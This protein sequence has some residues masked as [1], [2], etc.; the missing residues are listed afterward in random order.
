MH[1]CK[2]VASLVLSALI[3]FST[4]TISVSA[5]TAKISTVSISAN[6]FA[7][8]S[9]KTLSK[10][11]NTESF[12]DFLGKE[13]LKNKQS[14]DVS[15]Y[16]ITYSKSIGQEIMAL[17]EDEIYEVF[18]V[19]SLNYSILNGK[20]QFIN[21]NYIYSK[22]EF[23]NKYQQL[24]AKANE[25]VAD[26]KNNKQLDD[27]QKALIL[28]DRIAL[29]CEYDNRNYLL[30]TI[31][32]DS[33][34]I[35]GVLLN[36][37]AVCQGYAETYSYLLDMVGIK[38]YICTSQ[39]L[40]HAWNIV[41]IDGKKYHVDVTWDD[42][43]S[44]MNKNEILSSDNAVW[45]IKG[46]VKHT[47]F[48]LSTEALQKGVK[49]SSGHNAEDFDDS[50][51]DTRFDNFFWQN[52]NTGFYLLNGEIYYLENNK[53]GNIKR[54]SDNKTLHT[55]E[56]IWYC[57]G[58]Y[59]YPGNYSKLTCDGERLYY[60][61]SKD[62]YSFD[63]ANTTSRL[64]FSPENANDTNAIYGF[65]YENGKFTYDIGNTPITVNME[66]K[67]KTIDKESP[68]LKVTSTNNL[69]NSQ[70]V[71]AKFNDVSAIYGYWWGKNSDYKKNKFVTSSA[72]SVNLK[73]SDS[74]NYYITVT[75]SFGNVSKTEKLTFY[76][77]NF[78]ANGGTLNNK[79]I[80][81]LA[82]KSIKLPSPT[83]II[84][85]FSGW[86][87]SK[88]AKTG[89]YTITP[90]SNTTYYALWKIPTGKML[91]KNGKDLYY[92]NKG[93]IDKSNT[94][95]LHTDG[96]QYHVKNGKWVK[97]NGLVKIGSTYYYLKNGIVNNSNTLVKY[98]GKQYH[99]KNGKWVKDN[100]LVKIGSTYY[101]LK[102]GIVNNSNTLVKYSGKLYHV[103]NGKWVKDTAIIK[104]NGKQ[105]YVKGGIVQTISKTVKV[106]GKNYKLKKGIVTK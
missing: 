38:S 97:D 58:G 55:I 88:N 77:T 91:V 78:N 46:R 76:K 104:Y 7:S 51:T 103:K 56:D 9:N 89:V 37:T 98:S 72:K 42:P 49:D 52:S 21:P 61:T 99:V 12:R 67:S 100:G 11:V 40:Y 13:L 27:V 45:D 6:R 84:G 60:S 3:A 47:N 64:I 79:Y 30:D 24:V 48:L 75:D 71:T 15:S 29:M 85:K 39:S 57:G 41:Y 86:A 59:Y 105:Y 81:T 66:R 18:H 90:K 31:P 93:V 82:G 28:H 92:Y 5:K 8:V 10:Y 70:T 17:V 2:K 101:Y 23:E 33:Y 94:I 35:C 69:S 83:H 22:A 73:I 14:I 68:K 62:I 43:V 65:A 53:T 74:G 106:N 26:I 87:T 34:T 32:H 19:N 16:N 96:K 102:N 4:L 54:Y 80:V 36:G 1:F 25:M 20:L 95:V 44:S 63:T 50:P